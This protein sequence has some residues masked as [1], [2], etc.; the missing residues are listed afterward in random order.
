MTHRVGVGVV[1]GLL[2]A[3]LG[4]CAAVPVAAHLPTHR[5]SPI[6]LHALA[7]HKPRRT[8]SYLAAALTGARWELSNGKTVTPAGS[9]ATFSFEALGNAVVGFRIPTTVPAWYEYAILHRGNTFWTWSGAADMPWVRPYD[10][11]SRGI[12]LPFSPFVSETLTPFITPQDTFW[13][14]EDKQRAVVVIRQPE[15]STAM[16]GYHQIGTTGVY[17]RRE[18]SA[19]VV[20]GISTGY[21]ITVA[22][23]FSEATLVKMFRSLP[24]PSSGLFPFSS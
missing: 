11:R 14:F 19:T 18:A 9:D 16:A 2:A 3:F 13:I 4:G 22:G 8:S 23:P 5:A 6:G 24:L 20:V 21:F 10:S 15:F 1:V 12:A 7:L 17:W